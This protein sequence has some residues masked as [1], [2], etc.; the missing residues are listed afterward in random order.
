MAET[1][2]SSDVRT[3]S[4]GS[5]RACEERCCRFFGLKIPSV[6]HIQCRAIDRHGNELVA[7]RR[8][9]AVFVGRQP[10]NFER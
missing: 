5:A 9:N 2:T 1:T 6:Q 8:Q 10:V 4:T 3:R 7:H